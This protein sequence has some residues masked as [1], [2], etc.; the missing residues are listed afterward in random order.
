[1]KNIFSFVVVL[2][3]MCFIGLP[4]KAQ[5]QATVPFITTWVT[6]DGTI[7]IPT[8]GVSGAYNYT[9]ILKKANVIISTTSGVAGN[10]TISG[11]TYGDTYHV[12]IIGIF[13][14]FYMGNSSDQ[15]QS[16]LRTV[17]QWGNNPWI[18]MH[19]AFQGCINL[20]YAGNDVPD[21]SGVT[22]MAQMFEGCS[23]FNDNISNWNTTNITNMSFMFEGASVFNQDIGSW[24][25]SNVTNMRDMFDN[26]TNFNQNIGNW[27]TS[28]VTNMTGMFWAASSFNQD[29]SNWDTSNV[30]D[31]SHMFKYTSSFN[32]NIGGWNTSRVRQMEY[33]FHRATS[34]NQN[35]GNWNTSSVTTMEYMFYEATSFNQN[36]G[37]WNTSSVREMSSVFRFATSFNQNIGNWNTSNVVNMTAMFENATSFNQN[38]GNWNTSSVTDM[39]AMFENATSFNQ[40]IGSWNI[41]NV[42]NMSYMFRGATSF[43]QNIGNWNTSSV[44]GMVLMFE[45]ATSFNQNIGS[46]NIANIINMS[47]MLNNSGLSIANYDATLMGWAAQAT[48][49]NIALGAQG[50]RYCAGATAR[51]TL[52]SAPKNWTI[53]GDALLCCSSAITILPTTLT[54]GIT[55]VPYTQT[56]TQTGLTGTPVWSVSVGILPVGLS[57]DANT[58]IISGTP[59]S[60]GTSG[61]TVQVMNGSCSQTIVYNIEVVSCPNITFAIT[62]ATNAST[63]LP[64]SL[65]ASAT[66]N[67]SPLTYS[68]DPA[69]PAGLS[70]NTTTGII[71]GIPTSVTAPATYT[72][73]ASQ[74]VCSVTQSYTFAIVSN[75]RPF[76]TTWKTTDGYIF[77]P[78]AATQG[79]TYD[80]NVVWTNLTNAG[81]GNG[82]MSG[83]TGNY[84]IS[85]LTNGDTYRVEITGLFP[86]FYMDGDATNASKLFTIEQWG[87]NVWTSMYRAFYKCN[88]LTYPTNMVVDIPNLSNVTNMDFM[89]TSCSTFNGDL[90]SWNTTNVT[91]MYV[92]FNDCR[93]FNSNIGSWNTGN[94]TEMGSMFGNATSFN[95]DI[96]SWDTRN[97]TSMIGMFANATAFN[98]NIDSWNTSNVTTMFQMFGGAT[99]FNQDIGNWDTRNVTEMRLMF[100]QA[101]S[102]NQDIGSWSTS[103]VTNMSLMFSGATIFNQDLSRWD[104]RNVTRTDMMFFRANAFN[105]NLGSWNIT[106]VTAMFNMLDYTALSVANYDAT[107]IGWQSQNVKPSVP[108]GALGLKYCAS[109]TQRGLLRSARNWTITGD[110][111]ASPCCPTITILPTTLTGGI[112]GASYTQT[113]TQ[114]GLTGTPVWS[115]SVGTL[116][117]GLALASGTGIISGTPTVIGTANFT[118]RVT[119]GTC[120]QTKVYSIVVVGCPTITFT[121]TTVT[122]ATVEVAY[123]LDASA[124]S[125]TGTLSYSILPVLPA[126]LSIN[127]STGIIYGIP[128]APAS[129]T[130]YNVTATSV[131][132]S[133]CPTVSQ[134]YSFEVVCPVIAPI[135]FTPSAST[136]AVYCSAKTFIFST[137]YNEGYTFAWVVN[138]VAFTGASI[139]YTATTSGSVVIAVTATNTS[140]VCPGSVSATITY[141]ITISSPPLAPVIS[142]SPNPLLPYCANQE[143]TFT[144]NYPVGYTHAWTIN[145]QTYSTPIASYT[146]S[147]FT[148]IEVEVTVTAVGGTCASPK[149]YKLYVPST[150]VINTLSTATSVCAGTAFTLSLDG[151]NSNA[152]TYQWQSA[153]SITGV[154]ENIVSANVSTTNRTYTDTQIGETVYRCIITCGTRSIISTPVTVIMNA[155]SNCNICLCPTP[156]AP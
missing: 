83:N 150:A 48:Q 46:W 71:S 109:V 100:L 154:F 64:Y 104:T 110:A 88:N 93:L 92:M 7:T 41:A 152:Y 137:Q 91:T 60:A 63:G 139:T 116:P 42:I 145:R 97:V 143:F 31:M 156:K 18:S 131:Q 22:D 1:M 103:N 112:T 95:Q 130:T 26:A 138:G 106:N 68:I 141:P 87:D 59:T 84:I 73:T 58:G 82:T 14:R 119:N 146:P 76:I 15:D 39:S 55:G 35:I 21:L 105:Q 75:M 24:N 89:F 90:S 81:V 70:I 86:H 153:S 51:V 140:T 144:T 120:S 4:N 38:L 44:I 30:T 2:L 85:G 62:T 28:S 32:Q 122:T 155:P 3:V 98:K 129:L 53:T 128:T 10:H 34:F 78:T 113:L 136:T 117:A 94:V 50:L 135:E 80:Y 57:L 125:S 66:G 149:T 37:N 72:V 127:T 29:I 5:A 6:T 101:T 124:T 43:N 118:I 33:M 13:P 27:I 56:L 9:V 19:R 69:L 54:G 49:P 52:T 61:F 36:I 16:K 134:T 40:N 151:V 23:S 111:Q 142:V 65:D 67:T 148:N 114:T 121:N 107:L 20:T 123:S 77:I 74:G 115:V 12:E 126:G 96:G 147:Y 108:L 133:A 79:T 25:T 132:N 47:Y 11:L 102:F 17:E 8:Y 45:N 99:S